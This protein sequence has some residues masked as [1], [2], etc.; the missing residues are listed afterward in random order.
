LGNDILNPQ[1]TGDPYGRK[2]PDLS[3]GVA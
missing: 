3:P 1:D 2:T